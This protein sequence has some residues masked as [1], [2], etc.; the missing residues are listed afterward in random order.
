MDAT[1]L[2]F[3]NIEKNNIDKLNKILNSRNNNMTLKD[4]KVLIQN[5]NRIKTNYNN[6]YN[7]EN[8]RYDNSNRS[9]IIGYYKDIE[10]LKID[11]IFEQFKSE[12][13]DYL[14]EKELK[15]AIYFKLG[16]D[17]EE[18]HIKILYSNIKRIHIY[19]ERENDNDYDIDS[20]KGS[21]KCIY[22][23]FVNLIDIIERKILNKGLNDNLYEDLIIDQYIKSFNQ[24]DE[25]NYK[26]EI[27]FDEFFAE[28]KNQFS[29][30]SDITIAK[31]FSLLSNNSKNKINKESLQSLFEIN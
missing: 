14:N 5:P 2:Y 19:K 24:N 27:D 8:F 12:S 29:H 6:D 7:I 30:I 20:E 18:S 10:E 15:Q 4:Y 31:A 22:E 16:V 26:E 3:S 9:S 13:K 25:I 21:I 1:D 23:D 28:I 11:I 17:L